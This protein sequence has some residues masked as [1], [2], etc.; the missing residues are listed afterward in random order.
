MIENGNRVCQTKW[1]PEVKNVHPLADKRILIIAPHPDDETLGCGGLIAK[2]IELH[3]TVAVLAVCVGDA[4]QFGSASD[5]SIREGEFRGSMEMLGVSK[6]EILY[7]DEW[8]L[9][10]DQ[11]S[12]RQ[13]IDP[14]A[15]IGQALN[16][17]L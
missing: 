8:H 1:G 3:S 14:F 16:I 2:S 7:G 9:R 15:A 4:R 5:K 11:L 13:L 12:Q 10:L 17:A 6:S